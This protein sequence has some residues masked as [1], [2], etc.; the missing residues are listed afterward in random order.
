MQ[1][2]FLYFPHLTITYSGLIIALSVLIFLL[3]LFALRMKEGRTPDSIALLGLTVLLFSPLFCRLLHWYCNAGQYA[4][5][6][7]AMTDLSRGGYTS[8][9]FF[10]SLAI[11]VLLLRSFGK[12]RDLFS[13][14]DCIAPAGITALSAG[15]MACLFSAVGRSKFT[16]EGRFFLRLPFMVSGLRP[17][18]ETEWRIAA[19]AWESIFGTIIGITFIFVFSR[20]RKRPRFR[21]GWKNGNVFFLCLALY[22]A[23]MLV[24]DSTRYDALYLRSNGFVSLTQICC[25]TALFAVTLLYSVRS[26]LSTGFRT[27]YLLLWLLWLAAAGLGGY[28]EY[29]VQRHPSEFLFA[30]AVMGSCFLLAFALCALL[31]R[32]TGT[33]QSA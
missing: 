31:C 7:A 1:T 10:A 29:H 6:S 23:V 22:S 28:M 4:S 8:L 17:S 2:V 14:L 13:Q 12:C 24:L 9:G 15:R 20:I 21:K 30:Y 5:L 27:R 32:S 16:L 25:I 18:G 33:Q 19:F 3:L 11:S 26:V